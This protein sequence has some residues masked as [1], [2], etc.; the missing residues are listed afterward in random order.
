MSAMFAKFLERFGLSTREQRTFTYAVLGGVGVLFVLLPLG[1][2]ALAWAKR[3]SNNELRETLQTVQVARNEI[4]ARNAKKDSVIS[5]YAKRAPPLA[6][7]LEQTAKEKLEV[8]D[9]NDRQSITYGKR[10]TERIT[11]VHLK[12]AGMLPLSRFLESIEQNGGPLSVSRLNIRKRP[13]EANAFDVELG[14]SAFDREEIKVK[15]DKPK[16]DKSKEKGDK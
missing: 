5:R 6:G 3:A 7:Y 11:V 16:D 13:S 12:K 8:V 10:Y 14:I 9:S 1:L 15:D 4:R 2:T